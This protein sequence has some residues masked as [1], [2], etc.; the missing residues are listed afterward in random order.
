MICSSHGLAHL[1]FEELFPRD[2]RSW[3]WTTRLNEERHDK[4]LRDICDGSQ[5][6]LENRSIFGA[7]RVFNR[8]PAFLFEVDSVYAFKRFLISSRI[9]QGA[10][11]IMN[12]SDNDYWVYQ[13]N[14]GTQYTV[15]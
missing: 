3:E 4:R 6:D 11:L 12:P 7:V 14:D 1:D 9:K 5:S 2:M 8:L 13:L 10:Q 15:G